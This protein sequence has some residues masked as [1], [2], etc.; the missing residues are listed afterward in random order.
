MSAALELINLGNGKDFTIQEV[1]ERSGQS[2]RGFYQH[3]DGKHELLLALFEESVLSTAEFLR[4]KIDE[5]T[6]PLERLHRFVIEYHRACR[7]PPKSGSRR[8]GSPPIM[9]EFAQRLLTDRPNEAAR[10][11]RPLVSIFSELL[12]DAA[13]AGE[14]RSD[15][16]SRQVAGVVLEV[17]M[18]NVFSSTIGGTTR[19]SARDAAEEL[20]G[21]IFYGIG[22]ST[23]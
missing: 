22:P 3:F 19:S 12:D 23:A 14:V 13:A 6:D 18:F 2:L 8:K 17:T 21:L 1:V 4:K 20:W 16:P 9:A 7:P 10:A 15:L 5:E 11:F